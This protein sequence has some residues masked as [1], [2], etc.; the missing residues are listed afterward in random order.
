MWN[1]DFPVS[2]VLLHWWPWCDLSLWPCLRQASSR[3]VIRPPCRQFYNPTWSHT[4]LLSWFHTCCR[5]SFW[6][7]N[8][9]SRLLGGEPC[10]EPAISLHSHHVS[11][12]KWTT[13]FASCHEGPGFNP[14]GGTF[15]KLGF[16]CQHCLA[17]LSCCCG[18]RIGLLANFLDVHHWGRSLFKAA[19]RLNL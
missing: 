3:T 10:G 15:V 19:S 5:S 12:V 11:L 9:H 18:S 17:T 16:S 8:R 14:Q 13:P 7:H 4:A 2:V 1:R 6:L